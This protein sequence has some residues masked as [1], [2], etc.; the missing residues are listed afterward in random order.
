MRSS[1]IDSVTIMNRLSS[2]ARRSMKKPEIEAGTLMRNGR[3]NAGCE[4]LVLRR[5][6]VAIVHRASD[7]RDSFVADDCL[8]LDAKPIR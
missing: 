7:A 2:S 3:R 5:N 6:V 8:Q 1:C 4:V